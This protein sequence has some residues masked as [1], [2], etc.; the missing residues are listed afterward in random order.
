VEAV[1]CATSR[2]GLMLPTP[3]IVVPSDVTKSD[4]LGVGIMKIN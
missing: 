4:G 1:K 3:S 2:A